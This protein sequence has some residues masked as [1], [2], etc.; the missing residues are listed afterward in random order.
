MIRR[1]PW[2][3]LA[4]LL[5]CSPVHAGFIG[6][7]AYLGLDPSSAEH[8]GIPGTVILAGNAAR[9]VGMADDPFI[10]Y[11][12]GIGGL[13]SVVGDRLAAAGLTNLTQILA[14]DLA[15]A[16]LSGV[17]ALYIGPSTEVGD[18]VAAAANVE[19]FVNSGGG[20][21]VEPNINDALSWSWVPFADQIG[22]SGDLNW[23]TEFVTIVDAAHPVMDGLTD[24]GL[25]EWGWS[26]HS[27]FS[28]PGAAGF[29]TLAI[30]AGS[31][32]AVIIAREIPAP[33]SLA[34]FGLAG[35]AGAR[36]RR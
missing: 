4:V 17:A 13:R 2:L 3:V 11:V 30:D 20:L 15:T 7:I 33:G 31:G 35:L 1:A 9:W 14:A 26:I 24:G 34:L 25:S 19:S 5:V 16:D 10:A 36:R 21:V 18:F 28:S 29:D 12:E 32:L 6:R 27:T 8:A 22:H 23:A